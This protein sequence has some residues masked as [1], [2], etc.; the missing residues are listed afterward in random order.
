MILL[1]LTK[2]VWWEEIKLGSILLAEVLK[3]IGLKSANVSL[4]S[5]WEFNQ[6]GVSDES[7]N[8]MSTEKSLYH[9]FPYY[10]RAS[11]KNGLKSH[12]DRLHYYY[13]DFTLLFITSS[14]P[15]SSVIKSFCSCVTRVGMFCIMSLSFI[16]FFFTKLLLE[17]TFCLFYHMLFLCY[18]ISFTI[19]FSG[20]S[21]CSYSQ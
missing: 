8:L 6:V 12:P 5:S 3:L 14:I 10:V 18:P 13:L 2:T 9:I 11:L 16:S 7:R 19:L 21:I 15:G 17:V 1:P 20:D 4:H